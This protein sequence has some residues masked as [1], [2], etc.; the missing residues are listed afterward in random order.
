[1]IGLFLKILNNCNSPK[2]ITFCHQKKYLYQKHLKILIQKKIKKKIKLVKIQKQIFNNLYEKFMKDL[3][4]I[5]M[6][7]FYL[8]VLTQL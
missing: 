8:V 1:M 3:L 7:E 2:Y 5:K 4:E 6:L